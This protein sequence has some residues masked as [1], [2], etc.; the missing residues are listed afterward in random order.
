MTRTLLLCTFDKHL[1]VLAKVTENENPADVD[2]TWCE[3]HVRIHGLPIGKMNPDIACF[4]GSKIGRLNDLDQNRDPN[5]E[6]L[7]MRFRVAI[8]VIKPLPRILKL[9]M[10]MGDKQLVS[11]IYERLPNFCYW[12]GRLGISPN[13][14]SYSFSQIL[15]IRG[16]MHLMALGFWLC[17]ESNSISS[18]SA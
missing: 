9:R 3:F 16:I 5:S 6:G 11:F 15:L 8:D 1:I 12:C 10:V 2:L 4:I 18:A 7:Y 13:G 17:P 14:V